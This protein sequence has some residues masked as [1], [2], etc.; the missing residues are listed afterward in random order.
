MS[1]EDDEDEELPAEKK[2]YRFV[3]RSRNQWQ[4]RKKH[5]R[6]KHTKKQH[7]K[8]HTRKN[9][10]KTLPGLLAQRMQLMKVMQVIRRPHQLTRKL[11]FP[12]TEAVLRLLIEA[13]NSKGIDWWS[14]WN[15][16][17]AALQAV[18]E[19]GSSSS[20]DSA[21]DEDAGSVSHVRL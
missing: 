11:S 5:T 17:E 10:R 3:Q 21:A 2:S 15:N 8:K 13:L 20:S 14:L 16:P 9:T 1:S 4:K 6:K 12:Y 18:K 19:E 7:T